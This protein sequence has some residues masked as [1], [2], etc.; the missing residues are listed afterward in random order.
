MT[1]IK[2]AH[3]NEAFFERSETFIYNYIANF[4]VFQPILFASKFI[5]FELFPFPKEHS[6]TLPATFPKKMSG[7]W[8]IAKFF[9]KVFGSCFTGEDILCRKLNIKLIH[10]HFGPQGFYSVNW[11]EKTSIPVVTNFYGYDVS[12]LPRDPMWAK[13][14]KIL[15]QKGRL[16]LVEGNFMRSKLIEIGC[17]ADKVQIQRIAIPLDKLSFRKRLP[18]QKDEKVIFLFCGRFVEKK[19]LVYVIEAFAQIAKTNPHFEFRIIGTGPLQQHIENCISQFN[20][21]ENIK[22]LGFLN[23][24]EYLKE[25]SLADIFI[26]PSVTSESGDSEGGAPTVILEAQAMG[27]PVVSTTHADIPNIVKPQKSA[28]LSRERD[29][30]SLVS[31]I[32]S[33]LENQDQWAAMGEAGRAFVEQYHD[34]KKEV[35]SLEQK[36]SALLTI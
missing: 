6:F 34:I 1:K 22:L 13:R 12:E 5:N 30:P 8:F 18:K 23:Y 11:F 16:F 21:N 20:L 25:M 29:L 4:T 28:L 14:L 31:N 26:H 9:Q 2:I 15:F 32:L 27:L 17:P 10:A 19:G 3:F 7:E 35:V 33:V 36:Y 24:Q